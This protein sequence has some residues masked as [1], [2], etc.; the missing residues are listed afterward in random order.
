M[1]IRVKKL[2]KKS[3]KILKSSINN[4][5]IFGPWKFNEK[6]LNQINYSGKLK[7]KIGKIVIRFD[8]PEIS[9]NLKFNSRTLS[10]ENWSKFEEKVNCGNAFGLFFKFWN[11]SWTLRWVF[12]KILETERPFLNGNK[13]LQYLPLETRKLEPF[14]TPLNWLIE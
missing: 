10:S 2:L 8:F 4:L 9:W 7:Q 11:F 6:N 5:V 13:S 3:A 1:K 12:G 14:S